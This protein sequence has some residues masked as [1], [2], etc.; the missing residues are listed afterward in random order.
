MSTFGVG[1]LPFSQITLQKVSLAAEE[2]EVITIRLEHREKILK[3][4][5]LSLL[6]RFHTT[7]FINYRAE[8]TSYALSGRS[9]MTK[10][11]RCW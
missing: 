9:E 3:D 6:G 4:F 1:I 11:Y 8:K 7:K 10:N 5:S 2:D